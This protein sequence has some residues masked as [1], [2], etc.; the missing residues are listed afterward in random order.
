[1]TAYFK[2][3]SSLFCL[4]RLHECRQ[5]LDT[6]EEH[7]RSLA[8]LHNS[9][10]IASGV[11]TIQVHQVG[12][13]SFSGVVFQGCGP[14]RAHKH[15]S[16]HE[17]LFVCLREVLR[18]HLLVAL[19]GHE[20]EMTA[21]FF[22]E[23]E[24]DS[25]EH[26]SVPEGEGG[27]SNDFDHVVAINFVHLR[28]FLDDWVDVLDV[29]QPVLEELNEVVRHDSFQSLHLTNAG[30]LVADPR[31]VDID[32][33]IVSTLSHLVVPDFAEQFEG[34]LFQLISDISACLRRGSRFNHI[35]ILNYIILLF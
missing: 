33:S 25:V 29:V 26:A 30:E 8:V 34:Q 35:Q 19:H 4:P 32:I 2:V 6:L 7:A 9:G 3:C 15:L 28:Y 11:G 22:V 18:D 20:E 17:V 1:V 31:G 24:V 5:L 14:P 10:D 16:E 13:D 27:L 12:A 23:L 21:V